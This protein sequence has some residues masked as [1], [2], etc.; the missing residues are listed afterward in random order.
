MKRLFFAVGVVAACVAFGPGHVPLRAQ[1]RLYSLV[2]QQHGRVPLGLA[3]RR[4]NTVGT[5][6]QTDAHPDDENNG[7]LAWLTRGYGMHASLLT[8]TRGNGGQNEIGPELFEDLAVVRTSELLSAHR[9]DGAEQY[10]A[11]AIDFGF[12]FSPDEAFEK[13][14]RQDILDDVVRLI[15][16]IRPDVMIAMSP[17]GAGGGQHHQATAIITRD[18]FRA[19]A[20][21]LRFPDHLKA[22]L[23]PWQ[24]KKLYFTAGGGPPGGFPANQPSSGAARAVRTQ[25]TGPALVRVDTEVFDPLLGRTYAQ[26]GAE[27][28]SYH[29]CQGT[30]QVIPLPG[31]VVA[32]FELG[33]SAIPGQSE[34]S[35][36]WLF[37]GVDTSIPGLAQYAGP[38]PPAELSAGLG[39]IA[40]AARQAQ[41]AFDG[42]D[43]P[44][45]ASSLLAGLSGVR[46]LRGR[47][48]SLNVSDQARYD[49]DFRLAIKERDFEDAALEAYGLEFE[50]LA[51]DGVV[52]G[53]QPVRLTL[54][55]ANRGEAAVNVSAARVTGFDGASACPAGMAEGR[56]VYTC[57]TEAAIPR[58]ARLTAPYWA[59][60]PGV[61]RSAFEPDVPFGAPFRPSPFRA[62]F[63]VLLGGVLVKADMPVIY[64]Y[65]KDVLIGEKR[66]ELNVVPAYSVVVTPATAVVP[67]PRG[68]AA[69]AIREIH[70]SVS[71]GRKGA[72]AGVVSLELP[73]GWRSVPATAPVRFERE[74]EALTVRF[75]VS[76]PGA[77][78]PGGYRIGAVVTSPSTG[79]ERF[80]RGYQV[81]EYPH[82]QRRHVINAA[83]SVVRV[84]DVRMAPGLR[85]GYVAGVGDQVPAALEQLGARVEMV[86]EAMLAW[87]DLSRYQVIMTGIRAYERRTDLRAYNRRLLD[88]AAAGGTVIVQYNKMEFNQAQ[89]GPYPAQVSSNRVTDE[90]A[91]VQVLV[92]THPVFQFPNRID[93]SAWDGWVQERGL[94][95]LGDKD[96]RYVDLVQIEDTF[97]YNTGVK[98]GALVEAKVGKG[99][100]LYVALGLWRQVPAATDG[101]FRLLANMVSLGRKD[102]SAGIA[103]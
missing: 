47:L 94:Y 80:D 89:Y 96:S 53:G 12:S 85:I 95:F 76:V 22:G 13:W 67:T 72:S 64:R 79:S 9:L 7:L 48:G 55:V 99:R 44:A 75:A 97:P 65:Q 38:T 25:P 36:T 46:A 28:R 83:E 82:I 24:V 6:L 84:S 34:K 101:A 87:G 26:I 88:Y 27:A 4:V 100:W 50:A 51:D 56:G 63:G 61:S 33:E 93:A 102:A 71:N 98:R 74:D 91:P 3:I 86:D 35:E 81:V 15:R 14:G 68:G 90:R 92:P 39:D 29:K 45:A 37:D 40:G 32:T 78:K 54:L 20:D 58:D 1:N 19:A 31:P 43:G 42:G 70:V 73:A 52:V 60:I 30:E 59:S 41:K 49:I 16:T 2:S 77:V 11:R 69:A 8:M 17:V 21:P 5:F 57:T 66:M 18:A 62:S 10:H 23:R 103:R